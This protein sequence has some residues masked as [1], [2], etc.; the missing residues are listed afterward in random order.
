MPANNTRMSG[1]GRGR[2][3]VGRRPPVVPAG[4]QIGSRMWG[5]V[6]WLAAAGFRGWTVYVNG[7]RARS[8]G[9]R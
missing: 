1:H 2:S 8:R 9:E 6:R 3:A 4:A 7:V 5:A